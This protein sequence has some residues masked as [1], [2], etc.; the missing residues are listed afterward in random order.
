[1]MGVLCR[2]PTTILYV[3]PPTWTSWPH[4]VLSSAMD[5]PASAA[6]HQAGQYPLVNHTGLLGVVTG[7]GAFCKAIMIILL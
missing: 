6:A 7:V 1:M 4:R 3:I 5:T 2:A